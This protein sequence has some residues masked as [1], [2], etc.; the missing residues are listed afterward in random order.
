MILLKTETRTAAARPVRALEVHAVDILAF[1]E[2][3]GIPAPYLATP[4]RLAPEQ[5]GE[6]IYAVLCTELRRSGKIGIAHV[7]IGSRPYLAVIVPH[8]DA[9]ML[10]TLRWASETGDSGPP[11]AAGDTLHAAGMTMAANTC[12]DLAGWCV[13]DTPRPAF[14]PG[15]PAL[16][17]QTMKDKKPGGSAVDPLDSFP[18]DDELWLDEKFLMPSLRRPHP[19]DGHAIR[20]ERTRSPRMLA[21]RT[22]G[23]C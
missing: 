14:Q 22:R 18:D 13:D 4:Y 12:R 10:T 7:V 1:I 19:P 8:G 23:R 21:R 11:L 16:T 3:Q 17:E 9:L 6:D 5:G 15:L 20:R 2:A